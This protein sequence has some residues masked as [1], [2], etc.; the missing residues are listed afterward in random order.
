MKT[1]KTK[2]SRSITHPSTID[3]YAKQT[4]RFARA[5]LWN[6]VPFPPEE[7]ELILDYLREYY[8][9]I[10]PRLFLKLAGKR[11]REYCE[12]ILHE[13]RQHH[14]PKKEMLPHPCIWFNPVI[15]NKVQESG[16]TKKITKDKK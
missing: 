4:W 14:S 10:N 7:V 3:F 8:S 12:R 11:F 16:K 6:N 1:G 9:S 15:E 5:V 13:K 2:W